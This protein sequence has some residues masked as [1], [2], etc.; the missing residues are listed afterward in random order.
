[1]E[2]LKRNMKWDFSGSNQTF[3]MIPWGRNEPQNAWEIKLL[4]I[5]YVEFYFCLK[6]ETSIIFYFQQSLSTLTTTNIK[7][8]ILL[9][10]NINLNINNN[11]KCNCHD[12]SKYDNF[13]KCKWKY[14]HL[15]L[16]FSIVKRNQDITCRLES[17][18]KIN[19]W[20]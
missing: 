11:T 8:N 15:L 14:A 18:K 19:L 4:L 1:M 13:M 3:Q 16:V 17:S 6:S 9:N 12:A 20:A 2:F 7:L 10:K 5:W